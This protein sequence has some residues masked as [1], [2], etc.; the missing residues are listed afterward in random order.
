MIMALARAKTKYAKVGAQ[1][2]RIIIDLV[3]GLGVE[4]AFFQLR[5]SSTASGRLLLKTLMSAVAN[6]EHNK[7][8]KREELFISEA[9]IDKA[10]THKRA[11][12]RS[13]GMRAP[14]ERKTSHI[15]F[16][17]DIKKTV[18]SGEKK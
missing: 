9:F 17:V 6:A 16:G 15:T 3:R 13:R 2:A 1:K 18:A 10:K 12:S 11:W 4:E 5:Q 7:H 8:A 14:I